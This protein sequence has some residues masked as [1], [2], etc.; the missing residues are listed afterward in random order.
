M[1]A[2]IMAGGSGSRLNLGEKPLILIGGRPMI[3]YVITAFSVAGFEPVVAVSPNT[4]MTMNWCRA[5]GI[6]VCKADGCGYV[7]DMISAVRI[8]DERH[9]LFISVADI[10]CVT[11]DIIRTIAQAYYLSGKDGCST[12]VPAG[13][14]PS[15]RGDMPYRKTVNGTEACPAGI[16]ILRGDL[17]EQPQDELQLLLDEPGLSL[18]VNTPADRVRAE[19]FLKQQTQ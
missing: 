12:W 8:I 10:P 3:S 6:A 13:L 18:N 2:L 17:I 7:E 5:H 16:N 4:P 15:C 9:P 1:H 11:P 14:V 19:N